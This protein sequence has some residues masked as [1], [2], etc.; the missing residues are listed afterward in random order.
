MLQRVFGVQRRV[1][2][3]LC[4]LGYREDCRQS[5]PTLGIMTAPCLY[6]YECLKHI[7]TRPSPLKTCAD[8]HSHDT[9]HRD[10]VRV[11]FKRLHRSRNGI[12]YYAARFY[13]VIDQHDRALPTAS[14]LNLLKK[15]LIDKSYYSIDEFLGS[16]HRLITI[17]P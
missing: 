9:R 14:F 1:V 16:R 2:R 7:K 15:Y 8:V 6:I 12:N 17:D 13:N 11:G 10:D 3:T 5:F 4:G